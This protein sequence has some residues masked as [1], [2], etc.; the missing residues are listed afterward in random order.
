[1]HCLS[2]S[3][4]NGSQFGNNIF[5]APLADIQDGLLDIVIIKKMHFFDTIKLLYQLLT[6]RINKSKLVTTM[7]VKHAYIQTNSNWVHLDGEPVN[8]I[9]PL[10]IKLQAKA[11]KVITP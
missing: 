2:L 1:M 9:Q 8:I 6:K 3:I 10:H 7:K 4:A 5:I 11:L